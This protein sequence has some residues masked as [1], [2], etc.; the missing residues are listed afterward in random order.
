MEFYVNKTKTEETG[1]LVHKST[2]SSLP[3]TDSLMYIGSYASGEAAFSIANG[4]LSP[5]A[6]CPACFQAS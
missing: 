2:C 3:A 6:F 1:H 4:M 5:V